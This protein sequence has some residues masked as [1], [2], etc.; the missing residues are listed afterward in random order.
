MSTTEPDTPLAD[1][2]DGP[3]V[4][5]DLDI[6][7][8]ITEIQN[9][10]NYVERQII[11][12]GYQE[13][14]ELPGH[15]PLKE[16]C[17]DEMPRFCAGCGHVKVVGRTCRQM[18]CPRCAAAWGREAGT[19]I[20]AKLESARITFESQHVCEEC[21]E[22]AAAGGDV[23]RADVECG[24]WSGLK[25]HHVVLSPPAGWFWRH[26]D[27]RERNIEAVKRIMGEFGAKG[28]AYGLHPWRGE[29][30]DGHDDRGFWQHV[31]FNGTSQTSWSQTQNLLTYHPHVHCIVLAD[32]IPGGALTREI[33]DRTGW[34]IKRIT[35]TD[36]N[37]SIFGRYDLARAATYMVSHVGVDTSNP[38]RNNAAYDYFGEVAGMPTF[39][40]IRE[41]MD[42]VVRSVAPQTLGLSY[43][44]LVCG[45]D[46]RPEHQAAV[47]VDRTQ[48]YDDRTLGGQGPGDFLDAGGGGAGDGASAGQEADVASPT[49]LTTADA[50][51][52]GEPEPVECNGR[53][54]RLTAGAARERLL[55]DEWREHAAHAET[56]LAAWRKWAHWLEYIEPPEADVERAVAADTPPPGGPG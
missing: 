11:E 36:S 37:V 17:G 5:D 27:A 13:P 28:G 22:Q 12:E 19:S 24:H 56:L 40:N 41:E 55:D 4:S 46:V 49:P 10:E 14:L 23:D 47:E 50:D 6:E 15:G 3:G 18:R 26:P 39:D 1:V 20:A 45:T 25:F 30:A 21:Y 42:A 31:L 7:P 34:L 52:E 16:T 9:T 48:T 44:D 8:L 29:S 54:V 2:V 53:L 32:E 35:K 38:D 33:E 51:A 43:Q